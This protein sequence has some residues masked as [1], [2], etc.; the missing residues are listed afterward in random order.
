L[1]CVYVYF[2]ANIKSIYF[3]NYITLLCVYSVHSKDKANSLA[4]TLFIE[5]YGKIEN[6]SYSILVTPNP[7]LRLFAA[8]FLFFLF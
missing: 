2:Y 7:K 6:I 5:F 3:I 4:L 8:F 1:K